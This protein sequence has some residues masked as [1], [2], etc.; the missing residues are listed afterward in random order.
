MIAYRDA[1]PADG[2]ALDAMARAS[3][4][5]TFGDGYSPADLHAYLSLEH[6]SQGRLVTDLRDPAITFRVATDD[7]AIIGYAKLAPRKLPAPDP[8]PGS[9]DLRQLYVL[10]PWHGSGVG[11]ALLDW[12]IATARR[13]GAGELYLS[14][15]EHN[16]RA[17]AFYRRHGFEQVGDYGFPVGEQ[18]DR[19]LVM[20]LTL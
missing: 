5:E 7:A 8:R 3:C 16:P 11:A 4:M 12:T 10:R 20:R 14:V 19:D 9:M 6:G 18:I 13:G 1:T 17:I 2:P 15:W